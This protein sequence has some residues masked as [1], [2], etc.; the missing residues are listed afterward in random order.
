M[1]TKKAP[2]S[3]PL[4]M[5]RDA[6]AVVAVARQPGEFL[7]PDELRDLTQRARKDAQMRELTVMG[8]PYRV[9]RDRVLVSRYHAR[10]W[11]AGRAVAPARKPNWD[12]IR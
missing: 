7:D 11:L 3:A 9:Q 5:D 10:E 12:A 8:I 6:R 4:V 2:A 1:S